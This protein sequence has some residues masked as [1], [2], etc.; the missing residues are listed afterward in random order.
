MANENEMLSVLTKRDREE[1]DRI[2]RKLID[3]LER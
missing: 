1:L 2:T 3:H